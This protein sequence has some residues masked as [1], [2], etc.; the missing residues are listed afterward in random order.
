MSHPSPS[1]GLL[2]A[3]LDNTARDELD[4]YFL[5]A[6]SYLSCGVLLCPFFAVVLSR[7]REG[8]E[9]E[10]EIFGLCNGTENVGLICHLVF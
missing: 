10:I 2:G 6:H 4:I 8:L 5:L 3:H 7:P 1:V 9:D